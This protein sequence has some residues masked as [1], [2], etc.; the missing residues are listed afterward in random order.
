MNEVTMRRLKVLVLSGAALVGTCLSLEA[1]NRFFIENQT[2]GIGSS[3]NSV[4]VLADMD[5]DT[6]GYSVSLQY[7]AAKLSIAAVE[8]G[9]AATPLSPE[10]SDGTITTSP[11]RVFYGIV[12][13]LSNPITKKLSPGT[14]K[15]V[16]KLTI[17][18]KASTTSTTV[19]DLVNIPGDLPRLNVMTDS[20]GDSVS[21]APTLVDGTLTISEAPKLPV[22]QTIRNNSGEVGAEFIV[23]GLNFDTGGLRATLCSKNAAVSLQP[24]K[25]ILV[26]APYCDTVNAWSE[27]EICTNVGCTSVAEGFFY[28]GSG[29]TTFIRGNANNDAAVDLSDAVA[30]L[31]DL[32]LGIPSQAPCRDA[33]DGNDS[34]TVDLS[35]PIYILNFLFQGGPSIKPPYPKAGTDPTSDSLPPC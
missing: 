2:V 9:S 10:F 13:D 7:D 19:L 24:D 3:G 30:I 22:I 12:F 26:T 28:E 29:E 14:R 1:A 35:D 4:P 27:L 8:P 16:L 5:Q 34:G 11:G 23:E 21:P 31:N 17:D 20:N 18:V 6:Y 32:F 25:T 15:Q 33:L